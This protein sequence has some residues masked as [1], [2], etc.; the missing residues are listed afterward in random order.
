MPIPNP[1]LDT[2]YVFHF[3]NG[4][5]RPA[6]TLSM[7]LDGIELATGEQEDVG[8]MLRT[9]IEFLIHSRWKLTKI[10]GPDGVLWKEEA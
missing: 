1:P 7:Q 5:N 3:R 10:I 2:F 8:E 4:H 6:G 9:G